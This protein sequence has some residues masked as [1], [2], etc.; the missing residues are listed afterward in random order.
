MSKPQ[1]AY[2]Y[3][4]T[5]SKPLWKRVPDQYEVESR[6]VQVMG[7]DY[8]MHALDGL[9]YDHKVRLLFR[10]KTKKAMQEAEGMI[11]DNIK[12]RS[13]M[14]LVNQRE[15]CYPDEQGFWWLIISAE[16]QGKPL[17]PRP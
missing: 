8:R 11:G 10:F 5:A 9:R 4:Y 2:F 7:A 1:P 16:G 14:F 13:R 6:V 3:G 15:E 12:Y 17:Y